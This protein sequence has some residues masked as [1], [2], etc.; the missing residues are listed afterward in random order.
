MYAIPEGVEQAEVR[1]HDM[2]G[3]LVYRQRVAP[4]NGIAEVLPDQLASGLHIAALICDGIR[5]GTVTVSRT[6]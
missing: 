3:R 1:L 5:V 2:S 4:Q 6:R